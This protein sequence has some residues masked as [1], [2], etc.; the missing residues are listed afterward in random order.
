MDGTLFADRL[1]VLGLVMGAFL[2]LVGLGALVGLTW[3]T[4]QT[5]LVGLVQVI[6]ALLAI[7]VGA[8][9]ALLTRDGQPLA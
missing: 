2:V 3:Q 1:E 9:L 4:S 6:G 8:G 5:L 7:A